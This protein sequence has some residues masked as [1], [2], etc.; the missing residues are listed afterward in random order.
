VKWQA[1]NPSDDL[2]TEMIRALD[3][4]KRQPKWNSDGGKFVPFAAKWID[5]RRWE[6]EPFNLPTDLDPLAAN[7][8]AW[9]DVDA[10]VV[11]RRRA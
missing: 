4:Q 5:E 3:W 9:A 11:T 2:A 1:L 10:L 8:A 6:D 7:D